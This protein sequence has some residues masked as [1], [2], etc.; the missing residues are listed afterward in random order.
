MEN[1]IFP[2][3]YNEKTHELSEQEKQ[4]RKNMEEKH[5]IDNKNKE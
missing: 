4:K 2:D 5:K 3:L 1:N